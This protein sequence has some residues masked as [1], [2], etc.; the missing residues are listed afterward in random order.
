MKTQRIALSFGTRTPRDEAIEVL[1]KLAQE[2][3]ISILDSRMFSNLSL[4]VQIEGTIARFIA[5]TEGL[6][7]SEFRIDGSSK[8]EMDKVALQDGKLVVSGTLQVSFAAG[9]GNLVIP[10]PEVPG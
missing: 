10:V 7:K 2:N 4:V 9:D 1:Q 3:N 6:A 8:V 5:L